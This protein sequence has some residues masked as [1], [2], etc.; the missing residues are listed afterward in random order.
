MK[1]LL[2][3]L[4]LLTLLLACCTPQV[5]TTEPTVPDTVPELVEGVEG[6]EG[7]FQA[8][9]ALS[10]IDSLMWHQPDSAFALLLQFA[11]S[12]EADSLDTFNMNYFHVLLSELLYKNNCAQSNRNELLQ[13]VACFDSLSSAPNAHPFA[14]SRHSGPDPESPSPYDD[15]PFLAARTHYINGVGYY[16]SDSLVPACAEY[17]KALEVMED[18][19]KEKE[20]VGH[21]A[22]FM[23]Y[24][25][26]RLG[27]LF[28]GQYMMDQTIECYKN[29][30][31]YCRIETTSPQ[32]ISSIFFRIG[33]QYDKKNE[34]EKANLYYGLALEEMTSTDNELY[35][36]IVANKALASYQL[37][38]G[39]ARPLKTLI[40]LLPEAGDK[41][42][43]LAR[44]IAI[45]SI[46]ME[47]EVYDSALLYLE[48]ILE[49]DGGYTAYK[50]QAANYLRN[51]Y[52]S[53][54]DKEKEEACVWLL[55]EH[56]TSE[57]ENKAMVS[58]LDNLFKNY[59]IQKRDK[60]VEKA[61]TKGI[62]IAIEIVLLAAIVTPVAVAMARLKR[63]R[64]LKAERQEHQMAQ[65]AIAGRLKRKNEEIRLLRGQIKRQEDLDEKPKQAESFIDEPICRLIM[66]R[67]KEGQFKSKVNYLEY[68]DSALSKQQLLELRI[69]A[70]Q[71]FGQFTTRLKNAY[72][73]LTNSD[74]DYCCLYLLGL[75][76]A[77]ISALMQRSYNTVTERD[78]KLKK[79]LGEGKPL[80]V[81]LSGIAINYLSN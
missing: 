42:E 37:G 10:T 4:P 35:R 64:L 61:R 8:S 63:K 79:I 14:P 56:K 75:A 68:K 7:P 59:Q 71:H 49:A 55:A 48:P 26:N 41:K 1:R 6:V 67:V 24:I 40:Q 43:R 38:V 12:P 47:E 76:D 27:E 21:K 9:P 13:A 30:L 54:G 52:G 36:D 81:T 16:E 31:G 17:L 80:P 15:L 33:K 62:R 5:E 46:F 28:S 77:D 32:G 34:F 23:A 20:L 70:D 57:G 39:A 66:N 51:V 18:H 53:L 60:E 74:L 65:A 58:R 11:G 44:M 25:Y 69:A 22:R 78:T 45:G 72:P 73:R 19:Y 50:I 3:I 29:A 2:F